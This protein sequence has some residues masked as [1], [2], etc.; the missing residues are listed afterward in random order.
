MRV[1]PSQIAECWDAVPTEPEARCILRHVIQNLTLV[2]ISSRCTRTSLEFLCVKHNDMKAYKGHETRAPDGP[3]Y[4][5]RNSV[6][7]AL[8]RSLSV[9]GC[10]S[11]VTQLCVVV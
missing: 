11:S 8:K 10:T 5:W 6:Q 1:W 3:I 9:G 4:S 7:Y 2:M